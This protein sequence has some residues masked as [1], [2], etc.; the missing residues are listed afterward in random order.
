[1]ADQPGPRAATNKKISGSRRRTNRRHGGQQ[2]RQTPTQSASIEHSGGQYPPF[3]QQALARIHSAAVD[4]LQSVG[5]SGAPAPVWQLVL[6]NGGSTLS[7]DRLGFPAALVE[8]AIEGARRNIT[9]Y[10]RT[11]G[12]EMDLSGTRVHAGTGGAAPMIVDLQTGQ[13]RHSTLNDLY[14]AARLVDTLS[15]IRFFSRSMVATDINDAHTLDINT[16][17]A[18]LAGT[19][20]HVMVSATDEA[21]VNAIAQMCFTIAGS[22]QRFIDQPFLSLNINHAVSPLQ[23]DANACEVLVA[24]AKTG[25][26]VQVNT[27]AQLGASSPVTIAGC[28]AQTTAE[29]LAG[30]VIAWLANPDVSAVFGPRP[31][32]TDLRTG[33]MA[34]GAGEQALLTAAAVQMANHYG[35]PCSTIAGATDSKVADAQS[36]YE[37]CLSIALAAQSGCNLITQASGMQ[38]GLMACSLESYVI[39]NDMLGSILRSMSPIE[40]STQTLNTTATAEVINGDGHFLGCA[41]TLQR[42]QSDFLYPEIADRTDHEVWAAGGAKDI[43]TVAKEKAQE[44]LAL[45]YPASIAPR[46]DKALREQFDIRLPLSN[47]L[48]KDAR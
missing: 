20:K 10:G 16:A 31:M 18:S 23:F 47:M 6:D 19:T 17:Y 42:M 5:L 34:G 13:Y 46:V 11:P 38:A 9:L 7:N 4:L 29:T 35:L 2:R 27:F 21:S 8:R 40:V 33:G 3:D 28:V 48:G 15:N 1:M 37:K 39:D 45:H 36:G 30:M 26:P 32:I 43:R 25:I 24:A 22:R 41:E 12:H 14:N 44:I